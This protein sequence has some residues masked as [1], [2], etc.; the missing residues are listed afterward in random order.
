MLVFSESSSGWNTHPGNSRFF[1]L[2]QQFLQKLHFFLDR[3]I[4]ITWKYWLMVFGW[5]ANYSWK[6]NNDNISISHG[7]T[8]KGERERK[9][10]FWIQNG[11]KCNVCSRH[12][13]CLNPEPTAHVRTM[14]S[15]AVSSEIHRSPPH[16]PIDVATL[17]H[18]LQHLCS[19]VSSFL[20]RV[21]EIVKYLKHSLLYV[22]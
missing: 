7:Q 3:N 11:I 10:E 22:K 5:S 21:F 18:I 20:P 2:P 16:P 12:W 17:F 4:Y 1:S 8:H 15:W 14:P 13:Q 6:L 19:P 9:R